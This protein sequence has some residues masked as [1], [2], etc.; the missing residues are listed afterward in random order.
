MARSIRRFLLL[1]SFFLL[2]SFL[3]AATAHAVQT[4]GS[5]SLYPTDWG[6]LHT[7]DVVDVMVVVNN[8]STDTPATDAPADGV[9][10]VPVKLSGTVTVFLSLDG[11]DGMTFVPGVLKFVGCSGL[12]ANVQSCTASGADSVDIK[13]KAAGITVPP[14]GN[15]DLATISLEVLNA[16][17][18]PQVGLKGMTEPGALLACSSS[19]PSVCA[20]CEATGCTTLLFT[21]N[22]VK[23]CPH[24]C[25]SRIIYRGDMATP[26]F[27][28]FHGLIDVGNG[29]IAPLTEPF[30]VSLSN[31]LFNP[32]FTYTL[33]PGSFTAQGPGIFVFN[34]DGARNTGGIAFVK[35]AKRE[36]P[37]N[38]YKIDIQVFD[39]TL[40]SKTTL[41]D[42]TV[43][44]SIGDDPFQTSNMWMKKPN[45]W[46]LN[47]PR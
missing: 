20:D 13:L 11:P 19:K 35:I 39:A 44:F 8:T 41:A 45:G 25:P 15:V 6:H 9:A 32:I 47:L 26:D 33:P 16:E 37:P 30:V 43:S 31:A 4:G 7:G 46:F 36:S 14:H 28:E 2:L 23:P 18:V 40:E 42:M 24:P 5:I 1:P 3:A 29:A 12:N 22:K 27:F 17:L 34:N 10:A 38:E 21:A